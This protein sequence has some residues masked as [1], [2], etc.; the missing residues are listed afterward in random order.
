MTLEMPTPESLDEEAAGLENLA[1]K[2][3]AQARQYTTSPAGREA[4]MRDAAIFREEA[5]SKRAKAERMRLTAAKAHEV[6]MG[7]E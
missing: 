5:Q 2:K 4:L 6:A 7:I 1:L 3:E